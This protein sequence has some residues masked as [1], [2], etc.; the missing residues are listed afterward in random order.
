M[1]QELAF[2]AFQIAAQR[3]FAVGEFP[4]P[5]HRL[6]AEQVA[7]LDHVGALR[8]V[9]ESAALPE[10]AAVEQQRV[11]GAGIRA[12]P[13]DQRLQMREAAH[14]AEA[15]RGFGKIEEGEGVGFDARRA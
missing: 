4:V 10:I 14:A 1:R 15:V 12:Q 7:G 6:D 11:A 13:V 2:E 9:G 3:L 5:G 8:C